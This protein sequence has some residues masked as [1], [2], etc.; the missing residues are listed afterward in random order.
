M[1]FPKTTLGKMLISIFEKQNSH[2]A[3]K[4]EKSIIQQTVER[5]INNQDTHQTDKILTQ[6]DEISEMIQE[7]EIADIAHAIRMVVVSWAD[8]TNDEQSYYEIKC[9]INQIKEFHP[10]VLEYS[11]TNLFP[12]IIKYARED[13]FQGDMRILGNQTQYIKMFEEYTKSPETL[14]LLPIKENNPELVAYLGGTQA[15]DL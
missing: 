5:N 13:M 12:A 6:D 1:E 11:Q 9:N 4:E 2:K 8:S 15:F 7:E 14:S 10:K 3:T